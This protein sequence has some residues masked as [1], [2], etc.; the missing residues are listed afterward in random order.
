MTTVVVDTNVLVSALINEEGLEGA[1][2]DLFFS[3]KL[4]LFV[5]EPILAEY[6]RVL[7]RPKLKLSPDRVHSTLIEIRRIAT[8]VYPLDALRES[9]HESDNRFLECAATAQ[10]DFLVTGNLRHS[11]NSGREPE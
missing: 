2:A 9:R 6:Q 7:Q 3:Q 5:S 8:V 11:R 1:V 4:G 10:V